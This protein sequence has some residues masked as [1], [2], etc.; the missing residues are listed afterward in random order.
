MSDEKMV[1]PLAGFKLVS[2]MWE[3]QINGL[4]YRLTD[5]KEFVRTANSGLNIYSRYLEQLRKNQELITALMNIP[6]KKDIANAAKL[7]VQTE[8]KVDVL[9][10]KLWNIE[11]QLS[12]LGKENGSFFQNMVN[13]INQLKT[14]IEK[15]SLEIAKINKNNTGLL[16]LRQAIVDIKI[17][18]VN[19]QEIR[20]E[21]EGIKNVQAEWKEIP[22][23]NELPKEGTEVQEI[24]QSLAQLASIKE[25]MTVLK[26]LI[27][28]EK[29]KKP[30]K[31]LKKEVDKELVESAAGTSK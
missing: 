13:S 12:A 19:L 10:E 5:N 2:E 22:T 28:N 11:E 26:A 15:T 9:E 14:E 29:D 23:Q 17:M 1:D 18:Q 4:L 20:K 24:K 21:L 31:E 27:R 3:K 6:T 30:R 8:E 16:E 25:E 7:S